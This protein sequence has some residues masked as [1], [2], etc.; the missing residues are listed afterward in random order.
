MAKQTAPH[1][2]PWIACIAGVVALGALI[3]WF[4]TRLP[5]GKIGDRS[6]G[7]AHIDDSALIKR[8]EYLAKAGDC[9]ACHTAPGGEPF[10]GGLPMVAPIGTIYSSNITPDPETGIGRYS[11]GDFERAVRRGIRP[12]GDALYPAM[13]YPSYARVTDADMQALYAY[14]MRGMKPVHKPDRPNGIRWPLSMR[15]PLTYWRWL[16]AP[17]APAPLRGTT[18]PLLDR[19]AYL[20]EGLGHCG[21]CH[22]P[23]AIT[24]QEKALTGDSALFLSGG[25]ADNWIAPSLRNDSSDGVARFQVG[26]VVQ[27]LKGGSIDRTSIFGGMTDVVQHSTQYMSDADLQAIAVYLKS[28]GDAHA[29]A[30]FTEDPS[31]ARNLRAGITPDRGSRLYVDNCATCHRTT[32]KGY[33]AVFPALAGNPVVLSSDPSSLVHVVLAGSISPSTSQAPAQFTM[34]PFADRLSDQ[35]IADILSFVRTSWGN[36]QTTVDDRQ[37]A[38]LRKV[39]APPLAAK[40]VYDPRANDANARK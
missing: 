30:A 35:D 7:I 37:V 6:A 24:M 20:V 4:A 32:G 27:L 36:Q 13:P 12:D 16:F 33:A 39:L 1:A 2:L 26:D 40:S 29:A 21:A 11:Y 19:G 5:I 3:A 22:T 18:T 38:R 8:G 34:P 17:S 15:W 31:T 10:A 25:V 14:F 28:L 9:V 23:R